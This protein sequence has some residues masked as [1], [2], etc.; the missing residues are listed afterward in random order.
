MEAQVHSKSQSLEG[1]FNSDI[2][3]EFFP[4][5]QILDDLGADKNFL[6]PPRPP[7]PTPNSHPPIPDG[8]SLREGRSKEQRKE[9]EEGKALLSHQLGSSSCGICT[10]SLCSFQEQ[11]QSQ[12]KGRDQEGAENNREQRRE[13]NSTASNLTG[14]SQCQNSC[15][16]RVVFL[17][18]C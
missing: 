10:G 18:N 16:Y 5:S 17:Q 8:W 9:D 11:F 6:P 1:D 12:I 7:C 3:P 4:I 14:E 15:W 13:H 2:G